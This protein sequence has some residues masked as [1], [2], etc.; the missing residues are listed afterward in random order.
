ML[1]L[2]VYGETSVSNKL[3]LFVSRLRSTRKQP[4]SCSSL[5]QESS[6]STLLGRYITE[7]R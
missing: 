6:T 4:D 2:E 5:T 7:L 3:L 1:F